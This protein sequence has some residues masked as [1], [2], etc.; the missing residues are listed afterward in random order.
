[1]SLLHFFSHTVGPTTSSSDIAEFQALMKLIRIRKLET[2][3]N[4][5][6]QSEEIE[7]SFHTKIGKRKQSLACKKKDAGK[8]SDFPDL[9]IKVPAF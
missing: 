9:C 8:S 2:Q 5:K 4:S 1:M 6:F 3:S 7:T